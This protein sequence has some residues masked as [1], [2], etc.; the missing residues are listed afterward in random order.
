MPSLIIITSIPETTNDIK[1]ENYQILG[2]RRSSLQLKKKNVDCFTNLR[3]I[4]TQESCEPSL[5][6]FNFSTCA[7]WSKRALQLF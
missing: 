2:S 3:I 7:A 4:C 5:H 1:V 6:C